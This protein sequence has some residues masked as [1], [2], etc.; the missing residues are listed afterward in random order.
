M[1]KVDFVDSGL[2]PTGT[3]STS[4]SVVNFKQIV[5]CGGNI[6][7]GAYG[8]WSRT[9]TASYDQTATEISTVAAGTDWYLADGTNIKKITGAAGAVSNLTA[10]AGSLPSAPRLVTLYRNRLVFSRTIADPYNVYM[11]AVNDYTD[12]DYADES[13]TGAVALND[14]DAGKLGDVITCLVPYN[15]EYMLMGCGDSVWLMSGDPKAGGRI[16][17]LIRGGGI[18]GPDAYARDEQGAIYY[19]SRRDLMVVAPGSGIGGERGGGVPKSIS[20]GRLS[21]FLSQLDFDSYHVRMAWDVANKGLWIF[22]T[23]STAQSVVHLFWD[24]RM[25][26]FTTHQFPNNHGPT[27][28]KTLNG[29]VY[30]DRQIICGDFDGFLWTMAPGWTTDNGGTISSYVQMP[31]I[32]IAEMGE[33]GAISDAEVVL[34]E[35]SSPQVTLS[36]YTGDNA[37]EAINATSPAYTKV[38]TDTGR[39]QYRQRGRGNVAVFKLS[40]SQLATTWA[41]E[42]GYFTVTEGGSIR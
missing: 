29:L 2:F 40:N 31:P 28:V 5:G 34:G 38:I 33:R 13:V 15:D 16:D 18:V 42:Q 25:D 3:S 32:T 22:F 35:V 37:Q 11:S 17:N 26:A 20:Q 12:W 10:S 39:Y 8:S 41:Y 21:V 23:R 24:R 7:Y 1:S 6:F 9:G 14:A 19:L 27:A 36:L 30:Q 4:A